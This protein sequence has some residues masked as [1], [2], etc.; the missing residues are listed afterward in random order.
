MDRL[1]RVRRKMKEASLDAALFYKPENLFYLSGFTGSSGFLL[2]TPSQSY[3]LTDFRYFSQVKEQSPDFELAA[4]D[5]SHTLYDLISRLTKGSLGIEEEHMS[6]EFYEKLKAVFPGE[7]L[8]MKQF[9]EDLRMIKDEKELLLM[10]RAQDIADET[11]LEILDIVSA[12]MTEEDLSQEI[13]LRL[14]KKGASGTSFE[15][16]VASG[17]RGALP[18]GIASDKIM[19]R[20]EL[21]TIDFGCIYKGYCSDMTRTFALGRADDQQREI[22]E[23]VLEAQLAAMDVI[24]PGV[25]TQVVDK[26]ARDIIAGY[27]YA[28]NFGHGLGHSLGIAIHENPRFSPMCDIALEPGMVMTNE[29]GIYIEDF[30]GVRIEDSLVVTEDGHRI[31][32]RSPKE[33]IEV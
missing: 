24:K 14:R 6:V 29:P 21:V 8:P 12:G 23:I 27:G 28:Q 1:T 30:G 7:M 4:L 15:T 11:Y 2:I 5:D 31:M 17:V 9:I 16:I 33:L 26:T 3:I 10:Q 32:A 25:S 13:Y 18:H 22:Y 20:G 19:Q